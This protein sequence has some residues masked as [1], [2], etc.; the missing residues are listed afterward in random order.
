[1]I[2]L[3]QT[4]IHGHRAEYVDHAIAWAEIRGQ[5]VI[6]WV[7]D[8]KPAEV[9][10]R[11]SGKVPEK[12]IHTGQLNIE[13]LQ[14]L[15][16]SGQSVRLI[17][18]D[19]DLEL[20]FGFRNLRKLAWLRPI[21]LLMRLNSPAKFSNREVSVFFVKSA[22]AA[23]LQIFGRAQI[24]RLVFLQKTKAKL[25]G[26]VRDPLPRRV[27]SVPLQVRHPESLMQ[28]GIVGTL[29]QR[30]SIDLAVMSLDS[31]SRPV[32]L[33]LVGQ[34]TPSY[35]EDIQKLVGS[36]SSIRLRNKLLSENELIEEISNLD[37]FLVLQKTNAPS[38]TILRALDCGI[39]VVVGGSRVLKLAA[40]KYPSLVTWTK[41]DQASLAKALETAR[42]KSKERVY[43]LPTPDDF[44]NDLL[45]ENYA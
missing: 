43:G 26:Q 20:L 7:K 19:G 17:F 8:N 41:L 1:M 14:A 3:Y 21:Y 27:E 31:V 28:I 16:N 24:K 12:Y 45:G 35:Q 37:C 22:M 42:H 33:N 30:K 5:E 10:S 34:V 40:R 32:R 29:D 18:L 11:F 44:S 4:N 15:R 13:H 23:V 38:G 39:P 9:I 36:H 25:F 2:V 6:I